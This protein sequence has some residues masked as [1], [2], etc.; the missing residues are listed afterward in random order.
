MSGA[1]IIE[2]GFGVEFAAGVGVGVGK[3]AGLGD[4]AAEGVVGVGADDGAG[5]TGQGRD[6]A[7]AVGVEDGRTATGPKAPH[8]QR[9]VDA[10]TVEVEGL[11][12]VR[13]IHL[14]H[15]VLVIVDVAGA[16]PV[17]Q[18]LDAPPQGIVAVLGDHPRPIHADQLVLGIVGVRGHLAGGL[19]RLRREVPILV[20]SIG[21]IRILEQAIRGIV[22]LPGGDVGAGPVPDRVIGETLRRVR[23]LGMRRLGQGIE[24]SYLTIPALLYGSAVG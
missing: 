2:A 11:G 22:D 17:D 3:S 20:V 10:R 19:A 13:A 7:Q 14:D 5:G 21:E 1:I 18:F 4:E 8:G 23:C 16:H 12:G 24:G 6:R 15:N 9:L